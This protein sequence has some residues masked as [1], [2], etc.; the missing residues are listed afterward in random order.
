MHYKQPNK[1]K[2]KPLCHIDCWHYDV[3][4]GEEGCG[5]RHGGWGG[6]PEPIKPGQECLYPKKREICKPILIDTMGLCAALGDGVVIKG[7]PHDN[8]HLV[9]ILTGIKHLKTP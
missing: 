5:Q 1:Q 9:Q 7:G 2:S 6:W 4:G 3:F 8:T